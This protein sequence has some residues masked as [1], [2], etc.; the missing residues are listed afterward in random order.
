MTILNT[1]W[2]KSFLIGFGATETANFFEENPIISLTFDGL[3]IA[4]LSVLCLYLMAREF[5]RVYTI[6]QRL[7]VNLISFIATLLLSG[8]FLYSITSLAR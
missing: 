2:K 4:G 3:I 1:I 7:K 8:F 6:E 5:K